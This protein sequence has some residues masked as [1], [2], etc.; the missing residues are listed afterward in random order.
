MRVVERVRRELGNERFGAVRATGRALS[1]DQAIAAAH[2]AAAAFD[3]QSW[4][5]SASSQ[6][7]AVAGAFCAAVI[8][9]S[10]HGNLRARR[11]VKRDGG[12]T[13]STALPRSSSSRLSPNTTSPSPP[14]C[15]AGGALARVHHHEHGSTP[16]AP[17][18]PK[19]ARERHR[20][21][22][23]AAGQVES[24]RSPLTVRAPSAPGCE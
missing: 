13:I 7:P 16:P 21:T 22:Q 3:W 12:D 15:A 11:R 24:D 4:K 6:Q 18:A 20:P 14:A 8:A 5:P 17:T 10:S 23:G 1:R 2:D 9:K 19:P